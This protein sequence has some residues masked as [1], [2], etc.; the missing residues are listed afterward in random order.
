MYAPV[1]RPLDFD[2]KPSGPRQPTL[3]R[4]RFRA[5]SRAVCA[6]LLGLLTIPGC[7][8][9]GERDV[10]APRFVTEPSLVRNPNPAVP[11]AAIIE[12]STNE[13]TT[14]TL[15]VD[16]GNRQWEVL[17]GGLPK[18]QHSLT[19]VGLRSARTHA[20]SV[21]VTDEAGNVISA[22][23]SLEFTTDS[24]PGGPTAA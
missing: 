6:L 18:T 14:A 4:R 23:E 22:A 10:T 9:V 17:F 20:I 21:R 15:S 5:K 24:L 13:P 1:V 3:G 12:F 8:Q 11:L 2:S 7:P 19:V 16:D